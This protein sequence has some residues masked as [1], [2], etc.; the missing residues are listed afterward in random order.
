MVEREAGGQRSVT[1]AEGGEASA[2]LLI[3]AANLIGGL[4]Y[5]FQK[6]A[7]EGL[8][9]ATATLLRNLLGSALMLVWVL[10][11]GFS[12]RSYS[13]RDWLRVLIIGTLG[14][15]LPMWLG[16]LGT[17]ASSSSNASILILL[18]PAAI[19]VLA[20]LFLKEEISRIKLC[21][22]GLGLAGALMLVLEG[23]SLASLTAGEHFRGNVLLALHGLLWGVY[24]PLA[25]DLIRRHDAVE[26]ALL[27]ALASCALLGPAAW[28]ER[29][30]WS[31]S[32]EL[33]SS[34]LWV[35]VL[36]VLVT[37]LGTVACVR[38]LRVLPA[39]TVAGFV[40]LQPLAGVLAGHL[41]LGERLSSAALAGGAAIVCGVLLTMLSLPAAARAG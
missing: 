14:Y 3:V 1:R 9:P 16:I 22:V 12:P 26:I 15:G 30:R 32:P 7:L 39:S 5:L 24:T 31:A 11:R 19:L 38:S 21:G 2:V 17:E 18:E 33:A 13:A 20:R 23:G 6:L 28:L 36:G 35:A 4:S 29:G 40:F 34:L 27:A 25:R 41:V 10:R 8:P 37:F